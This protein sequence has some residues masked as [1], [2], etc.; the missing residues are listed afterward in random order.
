MRTSSKATDQA[1][2]ITEQIRHAGIDENSDLGI[3]LA[4][5]IN[6]IYNC[7]D[8]VDGI[9]DANYGAI[10][11]ANTIIES[12]ALIDR[13]E[14]PLEYDNILA[15]AYCIRAFGHFLVI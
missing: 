11:F 3:A 15:Q 9:W 14:D 12:A 5:T 8:N 13:A 4:K 1:E 2:A 6:D 10:T 7:H